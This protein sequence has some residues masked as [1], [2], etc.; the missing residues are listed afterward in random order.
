MSSIGTAHDTIAGPMVDAKYRCN[1][2]GNRTRFDVFET[3]TR[4]QFRHYSLG[5]ELAVEEEE[6]IEQKVDR[7][8]C[9]WC[10]GPADVEQLDG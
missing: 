2:C 8:V 4:R 6:I 9:R 1:A 7:V 10:E 5:G 3:L